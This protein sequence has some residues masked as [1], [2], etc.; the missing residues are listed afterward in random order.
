MKKETLM[1]L[2]ADLPD[3]SEIRVPAPV[4]VQTF[5]NLTDL[6]WHDLLL[7]GLARLIPAVASTAFMLIMIG[8]T[9]LGA[10]WLASGGNL[11]Q[12][13]NVGVIADHQQQRPVPV[14]YL[15]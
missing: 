1:A 5:D 15:V 4:L 7:N 8:V 9:I 6:P 14:G 3:G 2:L 12:T 10:R 13:G 11:D